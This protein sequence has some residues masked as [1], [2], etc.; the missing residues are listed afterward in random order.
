MG[1]SAEASAELVR[2]WIERCVIDL[3]LCPFASLPYRAGRVRIVV[4]NSECASDYLAQIE[5]ELIRLTTAAGDVETTLIVAEKALCDFLDF[6]DF[7]SE[8]ESL[9]QREDQLNNF[10][11]ASFHPQYQF[12]GTDAE[13]PGNYTNRAPF[14]IVQWLR[15]DTVAKAVSGTDTLA[16]PEANIERLRSMSSDECRKLFPWVV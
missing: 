6:N 16:I 9:L 8:A 12:A 10:Q 3:S 2:Q 11:I 1:K 14:P 13:D 7:L 15:A 5:D 4:C